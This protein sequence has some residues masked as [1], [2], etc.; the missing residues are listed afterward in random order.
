MY[1]LECELMGLFSGAIHGQLECLEAIEL[2]VVVISNKT[3]FEL[4]SSRKCV[5]NTMNASH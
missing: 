2:V 3:C 1:F 4:L 5:C